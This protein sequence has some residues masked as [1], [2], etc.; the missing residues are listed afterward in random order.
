MPYSESELVLPALATLIERGRSS[1]M[2]TTELIAALR[3][4][5]KPNG[6]DLVILKGRN[7]DHFSQKVRNLVSHNTLAKKGLATY[8]KIAQQ[9]VFV[10][11]DEG[12]KYYA[13]NAESFDYV[14]EQGYTDPE[15]QKAAEVDYAELVIEEGA[16]K[17]R[18]GLMYERSRKLA[19]IARKQFS[20][21]QGR[22]TCAG[23]GFE[24]TKIYDQFALGMIDIHHIQPLYL[25]DGIGQTRDLM[26]ALEGVAPLCPNCHRIVHRTRGRLIGVPELC[27]LTGYKPRKG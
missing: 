22:I 15:R 16:L 1:G 2:G 21:T 13:N 10:I 26:T 25:S 7:D 5:L 27:R 12:A 23:C 3:E 6:A 19:D 4:R 11:T 14:L 8:R 9:T 17:Q 18:S 20:D 24:G